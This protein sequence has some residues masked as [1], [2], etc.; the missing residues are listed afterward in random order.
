[1]KQKI[2]AM[3]LEIEALTKLFAKNSFDVQNMIF[4]LVS[5]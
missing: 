3:Q 2:A 5:Q 1:M 4:E